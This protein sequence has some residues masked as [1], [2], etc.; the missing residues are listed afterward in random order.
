[1]LVDNSLSKYN[2]KNF[3]MFALIIILLSDFLNI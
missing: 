3:G 1:M 2:E